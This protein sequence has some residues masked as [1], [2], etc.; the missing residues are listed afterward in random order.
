MV[1][2]II[3]RILSFILVFILMASFPQCSTAQKLQKKTPAQF[4]EVYYQNWT[5]G[6]QAG[7]SG[8]NIFI[9]VTGTSIIFD[10]VY[11]RGK[12][13]KLETNSNDK[14]LFVGRFKTETY[15]PKDILLSSDS[16]EEYAN[17]MPIKGM[18]VPWE[19]KDDQCV[20]SYQEDNKMQYYKISNIKPK[21]PI[22]FPSAPPNKQ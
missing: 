4:G 20:V 21:A 7:G 14:E 19:L 2:K 3:K 1:V 5:S 10:S 6:L 15:Q 22:N 9:P 13:S 8:L 18:K 17:Q 16:N 11:F 12:A